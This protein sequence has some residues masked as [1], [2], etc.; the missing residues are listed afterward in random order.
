MVRLFVIVTCEHNPNTTLFVV[1]FFKQV[2]WRRSHVLGHF[3]YENHK[4]KSTTL[5]TPNFQY[6]IERMSGSRPSLSRL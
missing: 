4:G 5:L 6:F 2:K 3:T 1:K